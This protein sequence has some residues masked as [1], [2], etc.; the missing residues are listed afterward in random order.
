[1]LKLHDCHC[2]VLRR[3]NRRCNFYDVIYTYTFLNTISYILH[4]HLNSAGEN[5]Q[6][7]RP[8]GNDEDPRVG[9]VTAAGAPS[10]E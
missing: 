2:C 3:R 8:G 10:D 5:D 1:M 4:L 6:V 9:D 7:G